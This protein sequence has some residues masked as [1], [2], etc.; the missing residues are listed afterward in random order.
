[1]WKTTGFVPDILLWGNHHL[2]MMKQT[3]IGCLPY[4]LATVR[5]QGLTRKQPKGGREE[6]PEPLLLLTD[7]KLL[8]LHHHGGFLQPMNLQQ[9]FE[10]AREEVTEV[11]GIA[12]QTDLTSAS[13]E[14]I[15]KKSWTAVI[16]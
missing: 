7:S 15:N 5:S 13:I 10:G 16:K 4:I 6:G 12:A 14:S 3:L 2:Y 9:C 11:E 1:M 8:K